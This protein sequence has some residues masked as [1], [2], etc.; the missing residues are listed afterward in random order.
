VR[1]SLLLRWPT[2]LMKAR[3]PGTA[4]PDRH[5]RHRSLFRCR[6]DDLLRSAPLHL[7]EHEHA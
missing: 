1:T 2:P 6:L 3:N 4:T 5:T 7:Q